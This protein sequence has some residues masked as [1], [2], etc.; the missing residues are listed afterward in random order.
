MIA[1]AHTADVQWYSKEA[2]S[3]HYPGSKSREKEGRLSAAEQSKQLDRIF[4][5][6]ESGHESDQSFF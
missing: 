4:W 6:F 3:E 2:K 5:F 1:V